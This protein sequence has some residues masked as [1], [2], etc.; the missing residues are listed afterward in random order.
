[1][2]SSRSILSTLSMSTNP[3]AETSV[4]AA[5]REVDDDRIVITDPDNIPLL[6]LHN[7]I[8]DDWYENVDRQDEYEKR[9]YAHEYRRPQI[10]DPI[11]AL[12]EPG[13]RPEDNHFIQTPQVRFDNMSSPSWKRPPILVQTHPL[14]EPHPYFAN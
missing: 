7:V 14:E 11:V 9:T 2:S 3:Q 6:P 4:T 13:T 5:W 12:L 1:E 10:N 8:T